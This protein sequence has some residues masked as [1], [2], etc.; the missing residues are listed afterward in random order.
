MMIGFQP[1]VNITLFSAK[2][3]IYLRRCNIVIRFICKHQYFT[4]NYIRMLSQF[5]VL[6]SNR[7][8]MFSGRAM[9]LMSLQSIV[10][11]VEK[12]YSIELIPNFPMFLIWKW[13]LLHIGVIR[14]SKLRNWLNMTPKSLTFKDWLTF[15]GINCQT[16]KIIAQ[17]WRSKHDN[18]VFESLIF[19]LLVI[20]HLHTPERTVEFQNRL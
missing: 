9:I 6:F 8:N 15:T 17:L 18:S 7:D 1:S 3:F 13:V 20:I 19:N 16:T 5:Q 2:P 4:C 12:L 10:F 14:S 11:F